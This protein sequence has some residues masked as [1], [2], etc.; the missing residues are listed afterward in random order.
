MTLSWPLDIVI[1]VCGV[2]TWQTS[3]LGM[4][5]LTVI[6]KTTTVRGCWLLSVVGPSGF[7]SQFGPIHSIPHKVTDTCNLSIWLAGTG[8]LPGLQDQP[9]PHGNTREALW[10]AVWEHGLPYLPPAA[11]APSPSQRPA[12]YRVESNHSRKSMP[13][14]ESHDPQLAGF[15]S[16]LRVYASGQESRYNATFAAWGGLWGELLGHLSA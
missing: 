13:G 15:L 9:R 2:S 12:G 4:R 1:P 16:R 5:L 14:G 6:L 3:L 7:T 10:V 11:Q 8:G